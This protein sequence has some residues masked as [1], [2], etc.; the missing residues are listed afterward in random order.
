MRIVVKSGMKKDNPFN[1]KFSGEE[2]ALLR[3]AWGDSFFS[4]IKERLTA[5]QPPPQLDANNNNPNSEASA[6][7]SAKTAAPA[8]IDRKDLIGQNAAKSA[9]DQI[10]SLACLNR[11]R[12]TRKLPPLSVTFHAVFSGSP[13]TGKTTFARFYA[14][15]VKKLGL[16]KSGHLVEV[17]RSDLIAEFVGQTAAKTLGLIQK[18]RGGILF[19][20]EAYALKNSKDDAFGQECIDTLVKYIEDYRSE[21]IVILA[22]YTEEMRNFL[23]HNTGLKSRIPHFILF[24]DYSDQ[25]LGLIFDSM[26]KKTGLTLHEANR[27]F[28]IRQIAQKRNARSFGNGREVRNILER[29][30][31]QQALRLA[32]KDLKTLSQQELTTLIYSDFTESAT[33]HQ[34]LPSE[35]SNQHQALPKLMALIGL[36]EVKI[37][38]QRLADFLKLS[39]LR[40]GGRPPENLNLHLVFAGNP[41]VGKSTVARLTGEIYRE[42]GLLASGH[43]IETSRA[44]LVAG[45]LGQTALKTKE[46]IQ[47]AIGGV[48]VVDDADILFSQ[49]NPTDSYGKEALDTL[50]KSMAEYQGRFAVILTGPTAGLKSLLSTQPELKR[51]LST[52]IEFPDFATEELLTIATQFAERSGFSLTPDALNKLREYIT[53]AK[54]A[55]ALFGNAQEIKNLL[56]AAFKR[57]AERLLKTKDLASLTPLDLKLLEAVD[58]EQRV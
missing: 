16:L 8:E 7:Q 14:Q 52:F 45:Y 20:D 24:E 21:L 58:I 49:N 32:T 15:E 27:S 17:T 19:I 30:L 56:E 22:G 4:Q 57:Q 9:L 41:G 39:L 40:S 47:E 28:V 6:P 29:A 23:H 2:E 42:L 25:E 38:I 35:Q 34:E 54:A 1:L 48:L 10:I 55:P 53:K 26:L 31:S 46:K 50:C 18:A 36:R 5:T 51:Q 44:D 13:G 37:E 3:E 33:D 12:A 11:E 43:L